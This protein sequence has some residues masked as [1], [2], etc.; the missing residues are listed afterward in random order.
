MGEPALSPGAE[1]VVSVAVA[2]CGP[3]P[4]RVRPV[5]EPALS[6][7]ARPRDWIESM[8]PEQ[9]ADLGGR[10]LTQLLLGERVLVLELR[11]GWARVVAL[12]QPSSLDPRGYPGWIPPTSSPLLDGIHAAGVRVAARHR[13]GEGAARTAPAC[14]TSWM[15]TATALR[16]DPDAALA[17]PG[18]T[19]GTR[20]MAVGAAH[21]GW[22]PVAVPGRFE[23]AWAIEDDVADGAA[24][25]RRPTTPRCSA[26]PT[27]CARC[28]T[29]GAAS[30]RT[31]W[32]AP[33]WS[34]WPGGGSA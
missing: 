28:R 27:G 31:A 4:D 13:D 33:A 22:L 5:D 34:T 21:D 26:W 17:V 19:F 10:T 12:G 32:T 6:V 29:S 3:R 24:D 14:G 16:D 11:G 30:P 1:A 20:L 9:R 18:V 7:P 25:A 15:A 8:S 2:R 23:P